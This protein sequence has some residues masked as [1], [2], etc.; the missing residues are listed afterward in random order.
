MNL[1]IRV[2]LG[3]KSLSISDESVRLDDSFQ[4]AW[5][6]NVYV[7]ALVMKY[8]P[9]N[10]EIEN[11]PSVL[12]G[13]RVYEILE[14]QDKSAQFGVSPSRIEEGPEG[15]DYLSIFGEGINARIY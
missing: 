5:M 8:S 14:K 9:Y 10:G 6:E 15:G 7:P 4:D 11:S 13:E 3:E 2:D 1:E 12:D